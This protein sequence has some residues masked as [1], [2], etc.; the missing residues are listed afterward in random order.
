MKN[1]CVLHDCLVQSLETFVAPQDSDKPLFAVSFAECDEVCFRNTRLHDE[2]GKVHKPGKTSALSKALHQ[3]SLYM[4]GMSEAEPALKRPRNA[5]AK[6]PLPFYTTP[7]EFENAKHYMEA[8]L[9]AFAN[10]SA[11]GADTATAEDDDEITFNPRGAQNTDPFMASI[12]GS[13]VAPKELALQLIREHTLNA[14]QVRAIAP[15]VATMQQMWEQRSDSTSSLADGPVARPVV[16]LF[17]GAGGS[18]KTYAYTKVLRP[19]FLMYFKGNIVA[20]A[21]THAAAR[22]LGIDAMTVHK[23]VQAAFRQ[24]WTKEALELSGATLKQCQERWEYALASVMDE[25]SLTVAEVYHGLG[26]RTALSRRGKWELDVANYMRQWFGNMP[27]GLQLGD[28]LQIRP[29]GRRSLCEWLDTDVTVDELEEEGETTAAEMGRFLFRDSLTHVVHF[30]GTGRFSTCASGQDLVN[31]LSHMRLAKPLPEDLWQKLCSRVVQTNATIDP[32][33]MDEKFLDGHEGGLVWEVVARLQQLRARR[34][35]KRMRQQLF[36]IQAVDN[37]LRSAAPL[38]KEDA[39]A[40]LQVVS[41]TSTGYLMGM[42]P[43]FVGMHVRLSATV[44]KVP[45]LVREVTGHVVNIQF[46]QNERNVHGVAGMADPM[47]LK[48]LPLGVYIRLD[49]QEMTNVHFLPDVDN[50]VVFVPAT[51]SKWTFRKP[52]EPGTGYNKRA[53]GMEMERKQIPLAPALI[54]THYGLQGQT[55]RKGMIAWLTKPTE[56]SAG[57]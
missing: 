41:L 12:D 43:L 23:A 51:T 57:D 42:V 37:A 29:A 52:T 27:I 7:Q 5:I 2:S 17:L 15:I 48:Y 10:T 36:Y 32:R 24:Q 45:L 56:M 21:P 14:D 13:K 46:H 3:V 53:A 40:A 50:G 34:D 26:F 18:G 28:F 35:A 6:T 47:V 8:R 54:N 25:V 38:S 20:M 30:K 4:S 9:R 19:L 33:L 11:D 49:D 31:I 44:K 1:R 16:A 39:M 22:L 55:P